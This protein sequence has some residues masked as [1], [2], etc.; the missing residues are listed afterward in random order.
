MEYQIRETLPGSFEIVAITPVVVATFSDREMPDKVALF[1][2]EEARNAEPAAQVESDQTA[3]PED[4]TKK[5]AGLP[6]L[7][8]V[9]KVS[10]PRPQPTTTETDP[11]PW[12]AEELLDAIA[13]VAAGEKI[14]A[15]ADDYGK[16][17]LK[18]RSA[19]AGYKKNTAQPQ[20]NLPS[21]MDDNQPAAKVIKAAEELMEQAQCSL[22]ERYFTPTPDHLD[23]CSRCQR[24]A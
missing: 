12:T 2:S 10:R 16:N 6:E 20:Q 15:V 24:G 5:P 11:N 14:M 1:L 23:T 19:W 13:R 7:A 8:P 22:C 18:L 17:W 21:V 3:P 4:G 9:K